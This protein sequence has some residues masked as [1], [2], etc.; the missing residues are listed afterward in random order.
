MINISKVVSGGM[1]SRQ[2]IGESDVEL[3]KKVEG[4]VSV[5]Q[6]IQA[7][8]AT[9]QAQTP[10]VVLTPEQNVA[11][12][13]Q[14]SL[15]SE[16]EVESVGTKVA[17]KLPALTPSQAKLEAQLKNITH[18]QTNTELKAQALARQ[19]PGLQEG[20]M[21]L[22]AG[23]MQVVDQQLETS[24]LTDLYALP[25]QAEEVGTEVSEASQASKPHVATKKSL[26]G[27]DFLQ[28]RMAMGTAGNTSAPVSSSPIDAPTKSKGTEAK[29]IS[30]LVSTGVGLQAILGGTKEKQSSAS[31]NSGSQE[32]DQTAMRQLTHGL[33]MTPAGKT[34]SFDPGSIMGQAT[35]AQVTSGSLGTQRLSSDAVLNIG[36]Q[37]KNLSASANGG[38]IRL[39]LKP[40]HLGEIFIQVNTLGNY[41]DLKVRASDAHA[42]K[43]IEESL[44]ALK[45]SLSVHN[46][47]LG[48][49]DIAQA[50][51]LTQSQMQ[52]QLDLSHQN[53]SNMGDVLNQQQ[54]QNFKQGASNYDR[55]NDGS[56][57]E[58]KNLVGAAGLK[59]MGNQE[60]AGSGRLNVLA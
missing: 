16:G 60:A 46:L 17:A 38:E 57:P 58:V 20:K 36:S 4:E 47:S 43:I 37:I 59:R 55:L 31:D 48:T 33:A 56:L 8:L 25:G 19:N 12:A 23:G 1:P 34:A 9:A 22:P 51:A 28:T 2:Q 52:S 45:E 29:S 26:S 40:D 49:I 7:A 21:I 13:A 50:P 10:V 11:L 44:S 39:R 18:A 6:M 41:V 3:K 15:S 54:N 35:S 53:R 14:T 42:K 27:S 5:D 24:T 32:K 30:E